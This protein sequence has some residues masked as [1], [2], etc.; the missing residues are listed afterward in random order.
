MEYLADLVVWGP[1]R[2]RLHMESDQQRLQ[3]TTCTMGQTNTVVMA[4]GFQSITEFDWDV[5]PLPWSCGHTFIN[6]IGWMVTALKMQGRN[7]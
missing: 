3:T 2:I 7:P 4:T 1:Y 6:G 5:A